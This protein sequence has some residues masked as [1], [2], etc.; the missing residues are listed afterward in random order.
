[1]TPQRAAILDVLKSTSSHPTADEVYAAVQKRIPRISLGTVYRNLQVL[2]E[3]GYAA[4]LAPS[5]GSHRFDGEVAEHHHLVCQECGRIDD[6][7]LETDRSLLSRIAR[8]TGY[9]VLSQRT[10][11]TGVCAGCRAKQKQG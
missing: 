8:R 1:M 11:Y 5:E 3:E 9:E 6:L 7:H 4:R 10:E 2:V